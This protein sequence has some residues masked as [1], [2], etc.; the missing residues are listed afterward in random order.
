ML[1]LAQD[2]RGNVFNAWAGEPQSMAGLKAMF[3]TP[4]SHVPPS[5]H[6]YPH[7]FLYRTH[8]MSLCG[9]LHGVYDLL[10]K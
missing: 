3:R 7:L 8:G 4:C 6:H 2:Y 1:W 10:L 5:M 9:N